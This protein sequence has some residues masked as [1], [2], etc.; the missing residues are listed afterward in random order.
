MLTLTSKAAYEGMQSVN[1]FLIFSIVTVAW[2]STTHESYVLFS[3][4]RSVFILFHL[5]V[6][7]LLIAS[8]PKGLGSIVLAVTGI[9]ALGI[10]SW[11]M[12]QINAPEA[13]DDL[14]PHLI[15]VS[16]SS[17]IAASLLLAARDRPVVTDAVAWMYVCFATS[18]AALTFALGGLQLQDTPRF[19]YDLTTADGT[20]LTYSQ[21]ISKFYGLAA[22]LSALLA[23]RQT[24][25]LSRKI[26]IWGGVTVFLT[27]S[28]IG[29]GRG[30]FLV[31]LL[32]VIAALGGA[33]VFLAVAAGGLVYALFET[34][35][36]GLL[37]EYTTLMNRYSALTES[38]GMRDILL[39]ASYELLS[40]EPLCFWLG[41]GIGFFQYY[42]GFR[43]GLYPH[44]VPVE[45]L[46]SFG[47]V[48]TCLVVMLAYF[49]VFRVYRVEG[50]RSPSLF[51]ALYFA[52]ISLK[53][54]SVINSYMIAGFIA[55]LCVHGLPS[56]T[57]IIHAQE[58][59]Y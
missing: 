35:I 1:T 46:V 39:S 52:L 56:K 55:F 7:A 33:R 31:S 36:I 14:V 47:V 26:A 19:V 29:G 4:T 43:S 11:G 12:L 54:G 34:E 25:G 57:K 10:Y 21:G 42:F 38:L 49:G 16:L 50:G 48:I 30:D 3:I 44:N 5:I 24:H 15:W 8:R 13:V 17:S 2:A 20:T 6:I 51:V 45:F 18:V 22:V 40:K 41:C 28:L 58:G 53:S 32:L 27:L 9:T 23:R 37:G 59:F